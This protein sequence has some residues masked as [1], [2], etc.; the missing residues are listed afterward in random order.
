MTNNISDIIET[1]LTEM[2]ERHGTTV[3]T[4]K[5]W[6]FTTSISHTNLRKLCKAFDI[7][8]TTKVYAGTAV[9][10]RIANWS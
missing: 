7:E 10:E 5:C 6:H 8:Y 1:A 2:L 4:A 9:F 3:E